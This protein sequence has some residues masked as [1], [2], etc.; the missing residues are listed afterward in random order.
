MRQSDVGTALDAARVEADK[1]TE[2]LSRIAG[3]DQQNIATAEIAREMKLLRGELA[4]FRLAIQ[5][6]ADRMLEN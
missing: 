6:I 2:Q 1:F 4:A 3:N 5:E